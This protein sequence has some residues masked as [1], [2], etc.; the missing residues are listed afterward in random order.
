MNLNLRST[1]TVAISPMTQYREEILNFL[2]KSVIGG[3][4]YIVT[5]NIGIAGE[6]P[7]NKKVGVR[8]LIKS[9]FLQDKDIVKMLSYNVHNCIAIDKDKTRDYNAI[10][11]IIKDSKAKVIPL[12]DLDSVNSRTS[13]N[14]PRQ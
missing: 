6:P 9:N 2:N 11:N 12:Q 10:A 13:I 1:H 14:V 8:T 3:N 4:P 5:D 7:L